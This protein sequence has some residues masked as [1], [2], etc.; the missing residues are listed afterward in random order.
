LIEKTGQSGVKKGQ[1][2]TGRG[3]GDSQK[4]INQ[5]KNPYKRRGPRQLAGI[6]LLAQKNWGKFLGIWKEKKK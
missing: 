3:V 1:G 2:N 5:G 4:S 6:F